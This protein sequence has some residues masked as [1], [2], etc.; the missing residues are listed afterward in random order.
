MRLAVELDQPFQDDRSCR[1]VD[2]QSQC[3]G[4]EDSF[5]ETFDEQ[6]FDGMTKRGQQSGVVGGEPSRETFAPGGHT[7]YVLV[8][9]REFGNV[10]V[11]DDVDLLGLVGLEQPEA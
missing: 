1:H 6:F 3:L 10:L 5:D 11:D 8:G 9:C 2:A 4:G 7:E